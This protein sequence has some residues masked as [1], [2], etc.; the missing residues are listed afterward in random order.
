MRSDPSRNL[1]VMSKVFPLRSGQKQTLLFGNNVVTNCSE[2]WV[3]IFVRKHEPA[4]LFTPGSLL[5]T[6]FW[7]T[8]AGRSALLG[9]YRLRILFANFFQVTS[10][11][12]VQFKTQILFNK[13]SFFEETGLT[14]EALICVTHFFEGWK[15][16]PID[17][18]KSINIWIWISKRGWQQCTTVTSL[19]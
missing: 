14:W 3:L 13:T 9:A 16:T 4:G 19:N 12:Y 2:R 5:L 7:I 15:W 6:L 10:S 17:D 8:R 1:T 18:E 11:N